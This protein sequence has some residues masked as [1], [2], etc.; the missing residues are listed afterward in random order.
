MTKNAPIASGNTAVALASPDPATS[1]VYGVVDLLRDNRIA[2]WAIDRA[3]AAAAVTVDIH[4]NGRLISSVVAD[5]HRPDL[6]KGGNRQRKIRLSG[7][8]RSTH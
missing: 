1:R 8:D 6:E 7:R 4:R 2:G 3:D 5:R